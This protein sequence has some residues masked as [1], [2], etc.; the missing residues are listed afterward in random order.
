MKP[1]IYVPHGKPAL[2]GSGNRRG[3]TG[4]RGRWWNPP[5]PFPVNPV[6]E[7]LDKIIKELE[8]K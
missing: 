5:K 7:D 4:G 3:R 8:N 1:K 2:S 6:T